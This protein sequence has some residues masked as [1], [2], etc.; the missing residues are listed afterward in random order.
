ME[1]A[2]VI[3]LDALALR[4]IVAV[5]APPLALATGVIRVL[6]VRVLRTLLASVRF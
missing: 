6:I 5:S 3:L 4:G 1:A 2:T